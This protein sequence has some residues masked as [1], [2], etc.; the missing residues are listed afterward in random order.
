MKNIKKIFEANPQ[1]SCKLKIEKGR[2]I[3]EGYD[4][5]FSGM[6]IAQIINFVNS[7]HKKYKG[8]NMPLVFSFGN[9]QLADKLSYILFECICYSLMND[10]RHRV[11]VYWSPEYDILTDGVFSCPLKL[12]NDESKENHTKFLHNFKM[13]IYKHHFRRVING[14]EKGN[15]NYLGNLLQEIDSFLKYFS[16][17]EEYRDQ[18]SEV[19]TELV[20]NACEHRRYL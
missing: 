8:V 14:E 15:T 10:Y 12:L 17:D 18:I 4:K 13:E 19:I 7:V 5:I 16:I 3:F 1:C 2:I 9:V 20:G 11:F 6:T